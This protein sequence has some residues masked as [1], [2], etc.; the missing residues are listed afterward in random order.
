MDHFPGGANNK[1]FDRGMITFTDDYRILVSE[2]A[3]GSAMFKHLVMDFHGRD[4]NMPVRPA[5]N[6]DLQ[7]IAWHVKEVFRSPGRYLKSA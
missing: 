2:T 6:P 4:L 1:L 3:T 7:F 5:Y